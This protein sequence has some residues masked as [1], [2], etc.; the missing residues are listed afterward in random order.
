MKRIDLA[1]VLLSVIFSG[2]NLMEDNATHL[3]FNLKKGARH[4]RMS[5]QT[6]DT[7]NYQ[8]LT[9]IVKPYFVE[10]NP[11]IPT[12]KPDAIPYGSGI[13]VGGQNIEM[14]FTSYHK[15]FVF[16]PRRLYVEKKDSATM[17]ILR[18]DGNRIE[19]VKL[20]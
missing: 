4:L 8:P 7:I 19:V 9:G 18:K 13:R 6:Q 11:T 16:V 2:C 3:A 20:F 5:K 17:I 10:I 15:R 14:S 12:I 1:I